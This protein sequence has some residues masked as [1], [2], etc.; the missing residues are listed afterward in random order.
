MPQ[1]VA[2]KRPSVTTARVQPELDFVRLRIICSDA[3]ASCDSIAAIIGFAAAIIGIAA[4]IRPLCLDRR[5][6]TS[7]APM[8]VASEPAAA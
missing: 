8:S 5:R 1:P 6:A 4:A 2:A 3:S 7:T